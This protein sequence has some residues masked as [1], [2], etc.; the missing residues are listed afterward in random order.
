METEEARARTS[1]SVRTD[2]A[3]NKGCDG[4]KV[5]LMGNASCAVRRGDNV[6]LALAVPSVSESVRAEGDGAS[7]HGGELP[8]GLASASCGDT[9]S[10]L[11]DAD[12]SDGPWA[13]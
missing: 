2:I 13:E 6:E 1:T 12:D 5:G 4:R 3:A 11:A 9:P 7:D 8:S 10:L